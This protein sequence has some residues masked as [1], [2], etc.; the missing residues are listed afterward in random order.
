MIEEEMKERESEESEEAEEIK[1]CI[2]YPYL[3]QG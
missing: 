1:T 3:L 2:L